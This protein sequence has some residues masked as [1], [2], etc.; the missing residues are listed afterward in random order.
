MVKS[1]ILLWLCI[2]VMV[3]CK[4]D[5]YSPRE[6]IE[7]VEEEENGLL[8]HQESKDFRY[9]FLLK[10]KEF[11]AL[12]SMKKSNITKDQFENTLLEYEDLN[13]GSLWIESVSGQA[14]NNR[15]DGD[16]GNEIASYYAFG[17]QKDLYLLENA[18]TL[19]CLYIH[20]VQEGGITNKL[21]FL[22][23]FEAS[24]NRDIKAKTAVFNHSIA[25]Q[26]NVMFNFQL[27]TLTNIPKIKFDIQ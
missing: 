3:S 16:L 1:K 22:L 4:K 23:A 19:K 11:V 17:I 7:W 14:V 9:T 27:K 10:P 20:Q 25:G 12:K 21:Q 24:K 8:Q 13:F 26:N 6:Y 5:M 18:D 2:V 15:K